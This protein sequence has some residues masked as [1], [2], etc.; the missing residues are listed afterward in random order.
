MFTLEDLDELDGILPD[1]TVTKASIPAG[2]SKASLK[3]AGDDDV[4]SGL[5]DAAPE[6]EPATD[7]LP[8]ASTSEPPG[9]SPSFFWRSTR[10]P[11]DRC[12]NESA[13]RAEPEAPASKSQDVAPKPAAVHEPGSSTPMACDQGQG[14]SSSDGA[15]PSDSASLPPRS[16]SMNSRGG[17]LLHLHCPSVFTWT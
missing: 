12:L 13:D 9:A 16:Q 11:S 14:G 8:G 10:D 2:K 1:S 7:S 5:S 6:G 4:L 15:A 17:L 3:E